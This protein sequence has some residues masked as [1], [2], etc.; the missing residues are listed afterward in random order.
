M[1]VKRVGGNTLKKKKKKIPGEGISLPTGLSVPSENLLDYTWLIYG[2]R[3]IGKTSLFAEFARGETFFLMFEP[4]A[5]GLALRKREVSS[6]EEFEEYVTLLEKTPKYSSLN[7]ID[8]GGAAYEMA[9]GAVKKLFGLDDIRDKAWG[10]GYVEVRQR[11]E[12]LHNRLLRT[13]AGFGVTAHSEVKRV[14]PKFGP[15]YDKLSIQ[16]SKQAFNYYAGVVDNICYYH[17]DENGARILTIRGDEGVE[18]GTRCQGRFLYPDGEPIK[19]IP[20]GNSPAEG[21]A[22]LVRAFENRL[23]K[24]AVK[25]AKRRK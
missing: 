20:M 23:P 16:L 7:V 25:V 3:K 4:G 24:P 10:G 11:F 19:H 9:L 21:Y 12:S 2:E 6:W 5:K 14:E 13:G 1:A 17:Y 15:A 22:N 8:T 18:A